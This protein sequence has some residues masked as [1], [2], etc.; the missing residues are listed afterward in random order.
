MGSTDG[1]IDH[2]VFVVGVPV[3][4][5][6]KCVATPRTRSIANDE[7]VPPGNLRTAWAN[8]ATE[9]L[10]GTDTALHQPRECGLLAAHLE[11]PVHD[12]QVVGQDGA[13]HRGGLSRCPLPAVVSTRC[14]TWKSGRD[15]SPGSVLGA[16]DR[17]H[18]AS[19]VRRGSVAQFRWQQVIRRF[20]ARTP[21]YEG[22]A[23]ARRARCSGSRLKPTVLAFEAGF[24]SN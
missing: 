5:S 3:T 1:R 20:L 6:R 7:D 12:R 10:L 21:I 13:A 4:G 18:L 15:Q 11:M 22:G 23:L 24:G 17:A 8:L 9:C 19:S 16:H 2:H 14:V